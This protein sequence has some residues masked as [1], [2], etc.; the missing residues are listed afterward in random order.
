MRIVTAGYRFID[1]DAYAG[2]IAFAE[3][4][5]AQGQ[6]ALAISTA[7]LN[8]SIPASLRAPESSIQTVYQP[9]DQDTFTLIDISEPEFF[10]GFVVL[11]RID[12]IIDHHPG[13]EKFW[14]HKIGDK[15]HIEFIG[16][17]CT[18]VY[19]HWKSAGLLAKMIPMSA[20]L[21][22]AGILDNTLNFSATITTARDRAAYGEL[23]SRAKLSADWPEHYFLG[24]QELA[25]QD[26]ETSLTNDT[27]LMLFKTYPEQLAVGQLSM[28]DDQAFLASQ[29]DHMT[30]ILS[31][32]QPHWF[33]NLISIA[34]GKSHFI[35]SDAS[36]SSWLTELLGVTFENNLASADRLWMR[37][38]IMK[39]DQQAG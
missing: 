13:L 6:E 2:C 20:R 17:A 32:A 5:R 34:E 22:A 8:S 27:K 12:E 25:T 24:C 29:A 39:R 3:L 9:N 28:W 37:K 33:M 30:A 21:L 4:L 26:L 7:P 10:D 15:A 31:A 36:V 35:C 1:I 19:E 38:E 23:A 11:D 16:A 18:L 14:H